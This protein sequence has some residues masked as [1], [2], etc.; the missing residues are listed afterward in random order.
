MILPSCVLYNMILPSHV[1]YNM[2]SPSDVLYNKN[3][4][5]LTFRYVVLTNVE[6]YI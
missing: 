2:I 3:N 6:I 1:L 4:Y 5:D